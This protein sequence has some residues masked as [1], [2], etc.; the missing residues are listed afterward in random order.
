[1]ED[2][3]DKSKMVW[4]TKTMQLSFIG[5]KELIGELTVLAEEGWQI[6]SVKQVPDGPDAYTVEVRRKKMVK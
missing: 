2:G 6:V 3:M 4:E 1:M 5:T